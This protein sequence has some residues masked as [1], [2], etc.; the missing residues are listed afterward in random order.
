MI[1]PMTVKL[2]QEPEKIAI[3]GNNEALNSA[4]YVHN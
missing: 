4:N 1:A 3:G 2:H